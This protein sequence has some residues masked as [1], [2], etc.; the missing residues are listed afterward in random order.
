VRQ[1]LVVLE[2]AM[3][4][5]LLVG[6]GLFIG[7]FTRLMR[8]DVGYDP[9][10]VLTAGVFLEA[11]GETTRTAPA[12]LEM[13]DR[14]KTAPGVEYAAAISGTVPFARNPAVM[15]VPVTGADGRPNRVFV[16]WV[17]PDYHRAL[18]ILLRM[19]RHLEASDTR[20]ADQAAVMNE[21]AAKELFAG[22][23]PVGRTVSLSGG[24]GDRR[25]VGI[26]ADTGFGLGGGSPAAVFIPLGQ[27]S[28]RSGYLVVR[29][30][31]DPTSMLP[32]VREA[33]RA[34]LPGQAIREGRSLEDIHARQSAQR[35]LTMQLLTLFGALGLVIAAVGIY[36]VMAYIVTQQRREIG[37]RMALGAT[38][39]GVAGVFLRQAAGV[40]V[41][42]LA[43]GSAGAW[44][45]S[46]AARPF[47][48]QMEPTEPAV[49]AG[50]LL[51]LSVSALAAGVVPARRAAAVDPSATLR[52]E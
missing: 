43:I 37:I 45:L 38:A 9:Q 17:T 31:G 42:G 49:F 10:H 23:N 47:L 27:R 12:L 48:F 26:V 2:I 34:V 32:M 28:A 6:A 21:A 22:Q 7:S 3:A 11:P 33:V 36:S 41:L 1:A 44:V 46:G 50:A 25:I 51:V 13:V 30:A 35:R 24:F 20:S 29:T 18:R 39:A 8:V 14:L 16:S 52:S 4:V 40:V 5:V 19:G 15:V